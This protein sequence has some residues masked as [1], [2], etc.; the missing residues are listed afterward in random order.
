MATRI[1]FSRPVEEIIVHRLECFPT[2]SIL[3]F[4]QTPLS[5]LEGAEHGHQ[6]AMPILPASHVPENDVQA[7]L[8]QLT[9]GEESNGRDD[10]SLHEDVGGVTGE[11][12]GHGAADIPPMSAERREHERAPVVKPGAEHR[13][14]VHGGFRKYKGRSGEKRRRDEYRRRS[15]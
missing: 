7:F 9:P 14:V 15:A 1:R 10:H 6:V 4:V 3:D 11:T 5:Q 13:H 8:V 12:A 2:V